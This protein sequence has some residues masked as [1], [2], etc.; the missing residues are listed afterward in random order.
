MLSNKR[1][2]CALAWNGVVTA[3]QTLRV[4]CGGVSSSNMSQHRKANT[5][6]V[7]E[8]KSHMKIQRQVMR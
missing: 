7:E 8:D 2:K 4:C 3:E 6:A 1:C 5:H